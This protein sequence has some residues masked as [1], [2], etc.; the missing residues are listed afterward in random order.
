MRRQRTDRHITAA[1]TPSPD[2][3]T[4]AA[5]CVRDRRRPRSSLAYAAI[6]RIERTMMNEH[7]ETKRNRT[8]S[9]RTISSTLMSSRAA[10]NLICNCV[11][12]RENTLRNS[13]NL[14]A[15]VTVVARAVFVV[16]L[17]RITPN[18]QTRNAYL[19][20]GR[21]ELIAL[22]ER[23]AELL[24]QLLRSFV[25]LVNKRRE[26]ATKHRLASCIVT[27][28]ER[29]SIQIPGARV[30]CSRASARAPRSPPPFAI[31]FV[32]RPMPRPPDRP[33]EKRKPP[34]ER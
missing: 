16:N 12:V 25:K 19:F 5:R 14:I 31:A 17:S 10:A 33:T 32:A 23:I 20:G 6:D 8:N 34:N 2:G 18:I 21:F 30:P 28:D 3:D 24:Q 22:A 7:N 26:H 1:C 15:L 29:A 13:R 4:S 11:E 27:I 9:S